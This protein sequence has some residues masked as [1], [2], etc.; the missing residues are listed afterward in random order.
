MHEH[1]TTQC[2]ARFDISAGNITHCQIVKQ[3]FCPFQATLPR[4]IGE[5]QN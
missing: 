1:I 3:K 5:P 4:E 2:W